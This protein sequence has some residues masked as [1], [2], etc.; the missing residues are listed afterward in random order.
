M[1]RYL[2]IIIVVFLVIPALLI[3]CNGSANINSTSGQASVM[4]VGS[5]QP[6]SAQGKSSTEVIGSANLND[7]ELTPEKYLE[8][9]EYMY[10]V[11]E[12]NYPFFDV[13]K[14]HTGIDWLVKKIHTFN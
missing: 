2:S 3:G 14:R 6:S 13:N 4:A 8:D 10:Q 12:E 5:P 1:R 9:F 11:L 7:D